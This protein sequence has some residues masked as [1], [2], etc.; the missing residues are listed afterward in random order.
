MKLRAAG[1]ILDHPSA[2]TPSSKSLGLRRPALQ[3][4]GF[5]RSMWSWGGLQAARWRWDNPFPECALGW[6][7]DLDYVPLSLVVQSWVEGWRLR[8]SRERDCVKVLDR[9]LNQDRNRKGVWK[10]SHLCHQE[11]LEEVGLGQFHS[12][13]CPSLWLPLPLL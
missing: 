13:G 1:A 11:N 12:R 4:Q 10:V 3:P 8:G 6:A 7:A 5:L 2:V 9:D